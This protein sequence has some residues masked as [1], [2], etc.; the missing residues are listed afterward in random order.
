MSKTENKMSYTEFIKTVAEITRIP[1]DVIRTAFDT[2]IDVIAENAYQKG[3]VVEIRNFGTFK[4]KH[5]E[6]RNVLLNNV[7]SFGSY[8]KFQF[9]PSSRFTKQNR[10]VIGE[11]KK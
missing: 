10:K 8:T 6:G 7:S 9:K 2:G 4:T 1:E 11:I 3:R 5:V